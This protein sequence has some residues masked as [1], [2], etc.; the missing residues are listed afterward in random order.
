MTA[1]PVDVAL[2]GNWEVYS[3]TGHGVSALSAQQ[4]LLYDIAGQRIVQ[5]ADGAGQIMG[6]GG[7][8]WWSSGTGDLVSWHVLDLG[9]LP[10]P[11]GISQ[12]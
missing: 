5:V 2:H 7:F 9:A 4:V 3:R 8:V 10:D 6:R 12:R 1:S 11:A